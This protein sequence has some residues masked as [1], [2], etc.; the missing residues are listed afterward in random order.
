MKSHKPDAQDEAETL[1]QIIEKGKV[2]AKERAKRV[3]YGPWTYDPKSLVLRH[4]THK[5]EI[6]I[7]EW[8]TSAEVLDWI[9]Q[10]FGKKWGDDA[11]IGLL[12]AIRDKIKPQQNLCS[13]GREKGPIDVKKLIKGEK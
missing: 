6:D 2:I 9:F 7:E 11:I 1:G 8:K 10:I 4:E 13:H 5:Y 12:Q 3:N